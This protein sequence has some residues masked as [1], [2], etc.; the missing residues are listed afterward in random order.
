MLTTR[1]SLMAAD[2]I[3]T[4]PKSTELVTVKVKGCIHIDTL[5]ES[6]MSK[7]VNCLKPEG[8]LKYPE[9]RQYPDK[10]YGFLFWVWEENFCVENHVKI[11]NGLQSESDL[12]D[13]LLAKPF[14]FGKSPWELIVLKNRVQ[15]DE[16]TLFFRIHHSLADG[17]SIMS[18][19]YSLCEPVDELDKLSVS[20]FLN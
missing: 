4:G 2:D 11:N 5:R 12:R 3:W 1:S 9:L 16:T 14:E 20:A 13:E 17:H 10:W 19:V 15:T 18:I 7:A 8:Q 6:V